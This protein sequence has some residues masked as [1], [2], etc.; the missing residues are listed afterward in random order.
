MQ[1]EHLENQRNHPVGSGKMWFPY[2]SLCFRC[3]TFFDVSHCKPDPTVVASCTA[4][5]KVATA[6]QHAELM[7]VLDDR[8]I[9]TADVPGEVLG[10]LKK[11]AIFHVLYS[12]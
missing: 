1:L 11:I 5:V 12:R 2:V 4:E 10:P 7:Q 8:L 6:A 9:A 3:G